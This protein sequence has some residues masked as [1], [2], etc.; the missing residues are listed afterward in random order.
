VDR[1]AIRDHF[2]QRCG[3]V[4][5]IPADPH[6]RAGGVIDPA[7]L[8]PATRDAYLELAALVA[9]GFRPR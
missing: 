8:A 1:D 2:A 7:R 4:V 5:E 9:D 3:H 6:L